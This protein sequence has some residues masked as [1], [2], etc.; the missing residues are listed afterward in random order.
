MFHKHDWIE[1]ARTYAPPVTRGFTVEYICPEE[2]E[3]ILMGVTTIVWQCSDDNC[4]ALRKEE[5]LGA[6]R[7]KVK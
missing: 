4:Q 1:I 6:E 2:F 7:I 5:M 3:R